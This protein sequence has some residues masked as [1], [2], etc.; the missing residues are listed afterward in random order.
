MSTLEEFET[1]EY[2]ATQ[3]W[4][5]MRDR[6]NVSYEEVKETMEVLA[7]VGVLSKRM[8]RVNPT[9]RTPVSK[10]DVEEFEVSMDR[11][12]EAQGGSP[13]PHLHPDRIR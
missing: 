2:G 12:L 10:D 6:R 7:D 1:S 3:V 4:E 13:A 9:Y 11:A 5:H 8:E